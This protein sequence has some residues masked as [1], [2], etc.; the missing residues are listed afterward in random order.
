[1][2]LVLY[3]SRRVCNAYLSDT[4]RLMMKMID[5][6]PV[7]IHCDECGSL[8]LKTTNKKK[9]CSQKCGSRAWGRKRQQI[10]DEYN[11]KKVAAE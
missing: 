1:L 5:L 6:F 8:F 11:A 9:Y 4:R 7:Y 2:K 10:V 3:F